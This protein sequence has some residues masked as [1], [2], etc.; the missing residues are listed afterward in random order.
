MKNGLDYFSLDVNMDE[1][2]ALIEAE[3]GLI[4][5]GVIV[6]LYQ[7]V[8]GDGYY[9]E[10]SNEVALLFAKRI[11]LGGGVVSEILSASIRRGIF[12]RDL[13]E[14]YQ[15]LTSRGIQKRYFEAVSRRKQI[16]VKKE[17]LLVQVGQICENVHINQVNVDNNPKNVDRNAQSKGKESK[18]KKKRETQKTC[19]AF[20]RF[21]NGDEALLEAL[22]GFE[23]ARKELKA[24]MN[25]RAKT[26][27]TGKLLALSAEVRDRRR[28]Q[29]NCLE[30]AILNGWK[31]VYAL[32][33]FRD[34]EPVP[35]AGTAPDWVGK[36][37]PTLDE[38]L[39]VD[40]G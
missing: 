27:L 33:E 15:I 32:K 29:V 38:I 17:Y 4:G 24:P 39:G 35:E 5:F 1:K 30:T 37:A 21:A 22:R 3:F 28:Y 9:V 36:D 12:D 7:K 26:L 8:Y 23:A 18:V 11:G 6:K 34:S 20:E 40:F 16:D 25:E 14:K 10:W 31:S 2:M 13:Y 19:D